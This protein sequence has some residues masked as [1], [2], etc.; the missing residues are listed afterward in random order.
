MSI[1]EICSRAVVIVSPNETVREAARRLAR[2]KVG[3]LVVIDPAA[4][5]RP[6]GLTTD[7]DL[8][9]RCVAA[10]LDPEETKIVHCMST[11][12]HT[13]RAG[14]SVQEA[15]ARMSEE[16]VRRLV[17]TDDDGRLLGLVSL[18]DIVAHRAGEDDDVRRLLMPRVRGHGSTT[19][20]DGPSRSSRES[21]PT[22]PA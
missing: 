6:I 19:P 2:R 22:A 14:A 12:V 17:V 7:R 16:G 9:V 15:L 18:D 4:D 5:D 10:G 13:I 11:P 21:R 3:T 8:V 1:E 20:H